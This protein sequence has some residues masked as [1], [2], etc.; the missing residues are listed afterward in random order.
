MP[1]HLSHDPSVLETIAAVEAVLD[2]H[3]DMELQAGNPATRAAFNGAALQLVE[4]IAE[5]VEQR[6][7]RRQATAD[8]STQ[9]KLAAESSKLAG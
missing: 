8:Q 6:L 5:A 7:A 4:L 3:M 9:L 1:T 2:A